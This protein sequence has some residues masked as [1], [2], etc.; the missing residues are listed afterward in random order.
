MVKKL[1]SLNYFNRIKQFMIILFRNNLYLGNKSNNKQKNI[2]I[3]F[4]A[5]GNHP[6]NHVEVMLNCARSNSILQFL[7]RVLKKA[8]RLQNGCKIDMF[9]FKNYPINSIE[10]ISLMFT[11]KHIYNSKYCNETLLCTQFSFAYRSLIAI[12]THMSLPMTLTAKD[13][14][15]ILDYDLKIGK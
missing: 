6:E 9:L 3:I 1:M 2:I 10:N 4:F 15:K 14:L 12:I 7:V 13:I 8:R 5:C 11:W